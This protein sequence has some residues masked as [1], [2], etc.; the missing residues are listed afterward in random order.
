MAAGYTIY[1]GAASNKWC[2]V[3]LPDE[4]ARDDV[5]PPKSFADRWYDRLPPWAHVA[6]TSVTPPA[7][8]GG[9]RGS[10]RS[11]ES[12]NRPALGHYQQVVVLIRDARDVAER[13]THALAEGVDRRAKGVIGIQ[14]GQPFSSSTPPVPSRG[15]TRDRRASSDTSCGYSPRPDARR[16]TPS[17]A[18]RTQYSSLSRLPSTSCRRTSS[19]STS[20]M[21]SGRVGV[22][23]ASVKG[24]TPGRSLRGCAEKHANAPARSG[25]SPWRSFR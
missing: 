21:T 17:R 18:H 9:T 13:L 24:D 3:E 15:G 10:G 14:Y 22:R 2:V 23:T 12:G 1:R 7:V 25:C 20:K 5:L 8:M 19:S 16:L 11:R 6:Q 4:W